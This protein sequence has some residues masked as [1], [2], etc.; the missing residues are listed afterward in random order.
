MPTRTCGQYHPL[1]L[2]RTVGG[3]APTLGAQVGSVSPLR[4]PFLQE[5]YAA[6]RWQWYHP[7]CKLQGTYTV[8]QV[9]ASAAEERLTFR[10]SENIWLSPWACGQQHHKLR[11]SQALVRIPRLPQLLR[12]AVVVKVAVT[13]LHTGLQALPGLSHSVP[14]PSC[15]GRCYFYQMRR[16]RFRKVEDLPSVTWPRSDRARL[17]DSWTFSDPCCTP[18]IPPENSWGQ[19]RASLWPWHWLFISF[20]LCLLV[21]HLMPLMAQSESCTGQT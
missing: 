15:K 2:L 14:K 11:T 16:L 18:A 13:S 17:L 21:K 8:F 1:P 3:L 4:G 5:G 7:K 10:D 6:T 9:H 12:V 19:L 20:I